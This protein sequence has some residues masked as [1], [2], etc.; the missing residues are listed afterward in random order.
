[1]TRTARHAVAV[2]ALVALGAGILRFHPCMDEDSCPSA[3]GEHA[4][5][6]SCEGPGDHADHAPDV[7]TCD[8]PCHVPVLPGPMATGPVRDAPV[9]SNRTTRADPLQAGF[10]HPPFRPPTA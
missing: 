1:M 7:R 6:A 8:C 10:P 5:A 4:D 9:A 2:I 3:C